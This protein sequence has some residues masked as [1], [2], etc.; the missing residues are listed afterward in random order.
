MEGGSGRIEACWARESAEKESK[1]GEQ[2][3]EIFWKMVY[4]NF[5]RELFSFF[6]FT[7]LR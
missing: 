7:F 6:S 1:R 2:T 4:E 5:F 3:R